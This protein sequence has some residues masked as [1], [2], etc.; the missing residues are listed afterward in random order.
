MVNCIF[1]ANV[2][3]SGIISRGAPFEI[4]ELWRNKKINIA[5]SDEIIDEIVRV[6]EYPHVIKL[7]GNSPKERISE[8]KNDFYK[9]AKFVAPNKKFNLVK[10]DPTDNKFLDC[11]YAA[12]ADFIITGD[13][14]LLKLGDFFDTKIIT[15]KGFL[16]VKNS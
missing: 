9:L 6:L 4:I 3:I 13:K 1:D 14:H 16:A 12:K 8:I 2:V 7:L 15:P 5:V 10:D 11:A